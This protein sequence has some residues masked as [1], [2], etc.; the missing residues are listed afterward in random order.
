MCSI[1]R[2]LRKKLKHK[3]VTWKR[4]ERLGFCSSF[5]KEI[6]QYAWL[7]R[8]TFLTLHRISE[9]GILVVMHL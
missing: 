2:N 5:F 4:L 3:C 6:L 7:C 9:G 1:L 8:K